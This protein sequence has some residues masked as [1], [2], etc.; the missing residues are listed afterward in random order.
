VPVAELTPEET[1]A[2]NEVNECFELSEKDL[3]P[4]R[5]LNNER[6]A[7]YRG[8]KA[9]REA[10]RK[11]NR[12]DRDEVLND[13]LTDWS[14]DLHIPLAY[15]TVETILPRAI[16]NR[17]RGLVLPNERLAE[18]NVENMRLLIEIQQAKMRYELICQ[19]SAKSGFLFGL[20]AQKLTWKFQQRMQSYLRQPYDRAQANSDWVTAQK[21]AVLW[22]DP[23]G[24]DID[25]TDLF[26]D[27]A[28]YGDITGLGFNID[29]VLHRTWRKDDYVNERIASGAWNTLCAQSMTP[30]DVKASEGSDQK[31][32]ANLKDR[33]AAAGEGGSS[34]G[35]GSRYGRVHEVWEYWTQSQ[36]ITVL[37]RRYPVAIRPNPFFHGLMPFHFYRP[38]T[39][40]MKR[41]H[42]IGEIEPIADLIREL[43]ILRSERRDNARLV[44]QQVFAFDEDA[45]DRDHLKFGPGMAIPVRG[46]DPRQHL[47]KIEMGDLPGVGYREED[48]IKSDADRTTGVSD[49][50]A[51]GEGLTGGA[52]STA[53]GAQL[54]T[55]AANLRI[56]NKSR[57]LE[58]EMVAPLTD[59]M[60]SLNQQM[61]VS[62][63]ERFPSEPQPG[64]IDPK[65][66]K[67]IKLTPAEL[68]G[69]M[70]FVV[71]AGSIAPKNVAQDAQLGQ[72]LWNSV[73]DDPAIVRELAMKHFLESQG[74]KN[75]AA[76]VKP[77]EPQIPA[78]VIQRIAESRNDPDLLKLVDYVMNGEG[79][80]AGRG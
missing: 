56:E 10:W 31:R 5:D 18:E 3:K 41:L 66:W 1:A 77:P 51:G 37:D 36:V 8:V 63:E 42:G 34:Q 44:L 76:W 25:I 50:T 68:A 43:N 71:D 13:A 80:G 47:Y 7:L 30:E 35:A 59:Q 2:R 22:D 78:A 72:N 64:E 33:L 39:Q 69:S 70:S 40:G 67:W 79:Q 16:S 65:P 12:N 46:D 27:P 32:D 74:V 60:I 53:T 20:G 45:I 28:G 23:W 29:W 58:A 17:P 57:R 54:V 4:W 61:I 15:S 48:V 21:N 75:A 19:E 6:Y 49:A 24:E 14:S 38:T 11:G 52:A 73:K 62:R 9:Y 26:W 55:A